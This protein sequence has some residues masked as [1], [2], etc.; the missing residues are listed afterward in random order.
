M[1]KNTRNEVEYTDHA[2]L[3]GLGMFGQQIGLFDALDEV[4]FPGRVYQRSPQRKLREL[5]AALAA[6]YRHLQD[7]DLAPDALRADPIAV[8]AW[9][10]K[11]FAHYTGVS[12]GIRRADSRTVSELQAA[13]EKVSTPFL[14][15]DLE[16]ALA[17]GGPLR[18]EGDTTGLGTTADMLGV[19]AGL[20]EGR[21]QPGFRM[22]SVSLRTPFY[23]VILGSAHFNGKRVACQTLEALI[24][25]AE[26]RIG[27][28]RR[29]VELLQAQLE[30]LKQKEAHWR[31]RAQRAQA[32]ARQHEQR[33]WERH[34]LLRQIQGELKRLE[35]QYAGRE[36][37]PY[38][39][40]A[41]ARRHQQTYQR[42]QA[43]ARRRQQQAQETARRFLKRSMRVWE[44]QR[45]LRT[46]IACYE[47][48]NRS[49][50]RPLEIV[51]SL[52]GGFGTPDNVA[53]LT[54]LGYEVSSKAHGQTATPQLKREVNPDTEWEM[55]N[56]I[57][58]VTQ[59]QRTQFGRC[60][61]PVRLLLTRQQ[62]GERVRHSTLVI[63]P[64][65]AQWGRRS[66]LSPYQLGAAESVR[67]YNRRQDI[68]AGIKEFKGVFHLGHM[69][70][71]S[72]EA[73]QIQEQLIAFLPNFIR[74]AIRYYFRPN[75]IHL[76]NRAD[77]GLAQL[78]NTVRVA[79]RSQAQVHYEADGCV[80]RFA[81]KGAFAGL[82]IDLRQ[83]FVFQLPLP[84]FSKLSIF[85]SVHK[86]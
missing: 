40:L 71:F 74:W 31:Q 67:F 2:L 77:R 47:R 76:P 35:A 70:F 55:V 1:A 3:V 36:A 38:S 60:L 42:W 66:D 46:R 37:K 14:A 62:R 13:L 21:L 48:D 57:T 39:R 32:R 24:S 28:P 64:P 61:Y 79:M 63:S 52:D 33:F 41:K 69:R 27:R 10:G 82:V 43:A 84:L 83:P 16:E 4:H 68:E 26:R 11:G 73:I 9:D 5:L 18:L 65:D 80:L 6:G 34:F 8:A 15:R 19:E 49:N 85:E 59:S 20:I 58:Q 22:A 23:R 50:P 72:A 86:T 30:G 53:L 75:A 45:S 56:S 12:R 29:R 81:A 25:L 44:Q 17:S 54:E 78:R 7:I 51:F